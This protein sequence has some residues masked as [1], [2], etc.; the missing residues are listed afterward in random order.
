MDEAG[1]L[2]LWRWSTLVQVS[3]LAMIAAFF[4]LL[5]RTNPR[6]ELKWWA[7]AWAFNLI[8]ILVTSVT[9]MSQA[10]L[11]LPAVT[12]VYT[13]GKTAF[14]LLLMQGVW[15]MI[16]PGGRLFTTRGATIGVITYAVAATILLRDVTSVGIVQHSFIGVALIVFAIVLLRTRPTA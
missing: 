12:L 16:R 3:S 10:D 13:S 2:L 6:A 14:T 11:L 5:A 7:R 4:A 8:A 9:W 1:Q 15:T